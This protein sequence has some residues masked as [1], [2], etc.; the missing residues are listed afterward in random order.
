M[1][2]DAVDIKKYTSIYDIKQ[3]NF[4]ILPFQMSYMTMTVIS[5]CEV[6]LEPIQSTESICRGRGSVYCK[7]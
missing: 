7:H 3:I 2:P 6:C 1:L 4:A 5:H